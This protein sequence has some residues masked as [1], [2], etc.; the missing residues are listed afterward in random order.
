VTSLSKCV[1]WVISGFCREVDEN[2][3][4]LCCYAA[5]NVISNRH[6]PETSVKI[7]YYSL[8]NN[9]EGRSSRT[10]ISLQLLFICF[11]VEINFWIGLLFK[12]FVLYFTVQILLRQNCFLPLAHMQSVGWMDESDSRQ[13]FFHN[14]SWRH[15]APTLC[16]IIL[17]SRFLYKHSRW[18]G[19]KLTFTS[20]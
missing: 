2:C 19:V 8:R 11:T 5:S 9:L 18:R 20:I 4:L 10:C 6:R 12:V 14:S 15:L 17:I 7:Y 1:L 16:F 3:T 13:A